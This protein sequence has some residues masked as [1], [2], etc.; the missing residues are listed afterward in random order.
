MTL[1]NYS[2]IYNEF[3]DFSNIEDI[4]EYFLGSKKA[5]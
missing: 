5:S 3:L 2:F 1:S 4:I